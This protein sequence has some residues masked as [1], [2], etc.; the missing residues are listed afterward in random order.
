M[1]NLEIKLMGKYYSQYLQDRFCDQVI[2]NGKNNGFF[3][4]IGAYDGITFSNSYF[5]EKNK[6]WSGVCF[7]PNPSVF[8]NLVKNRNC[9]CIN[10][11]IGPEEKVL[12]YLKINGPGEMLSGFKDFFDLRHFERIKRETLN[13]LE[14]EEEIPVQI[15]ILSSFLEN[16]SV[17]LLSLDTEGNELE[18]LK[19]IDFNKFPCKVI[20][21]ENNYRTLDTEFYLKGEGYQ[22]LIRLGCD[23]IFILNSEL[24]YFILVK[25]LIWKLRRRINL[26]KKGFRKR[27]RLLKF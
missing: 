9:E 16:K 5:F 14:S 1:E 20:S 27:L 7:E 18:I 3:L 26:H 25:T 21:V 4:D 8:L 13:T 10:V 12:T 2:F 17:D 22:K 23:E 24:S 15:A 11:G 6:N 19:S